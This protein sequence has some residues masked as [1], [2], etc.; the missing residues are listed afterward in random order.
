MAPAMVPHV[1][2]SPQ[3]SP[4]IKPPPFS[5]PT[6]TGHCGTTPPTMQ[7]VIRKTALA[8]NQAQRKAIRATKNAEREDLKDSLRQRF[9]YN[10]LELDVARAERQRRRED[11]LRG[12]LAPQRD[13]GFDGKSFGAL[14]PQAMNPPAIP[15]HLRRK[16]INIA[17]GDRVCI[18]K[19]KDKGKI[20]EVVR[21]DANNETVMVKDLNMVCSRFPSL[22]RELCVVLGWAD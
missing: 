5:D 7:K 18:M 11:W 21:V 9:A 22:L 19:G 1:T 13:A 6:T 15:K 10:R 14:S 20:N 17:A 4:S 3:F 8:R 16:Y 2:Q 12:P